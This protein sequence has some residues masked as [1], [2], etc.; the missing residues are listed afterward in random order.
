[1]DVMDKSGTLNI[2]W[3]VSMLNKIIGYVFKKSK[4]INN[5]NLRNVQKLLK[6]CNYEQYKNRPVVMERVT[7]I[8]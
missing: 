1:M 2:R 7:F 5:L 8:L 4:N 6:D 3:D